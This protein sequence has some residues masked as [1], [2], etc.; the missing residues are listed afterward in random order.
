MW[1]RRKDIFT[2][3]D[4]IN[5]SITKV[6]VEQPLA[7][8]GSA[9][10]VDLHKKYAK[11]RYIMSL[12]IITQT[13]TLKKDKNQEKMGSNWRKNR[14]PIPAYA[15]PFPANSSPFQLIPA[16]FS[17]FKPISAYSN[18]FQH[19]TAYN[20]LSQYITASSS[21]FLLISSPFQ[22]IPAAH[23]RERE[24][25][26]L[27]LGHQQYKQQWAVPKKIVCTQQVA[28]QS[29]IWTGIHVGGNGKIQCYS[30]QQNDFFLYIIFISVREH[31]YEA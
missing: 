8:P 31:F 11:H 3:H 6:F 9:K 20:S 27:L 19:I 28:S 18:L 14:K 25:R 12:K 15:S 10:K 4:S 23:E 21:L 29:K 13:K 26:A 7:S 5:Q 24:R 30:L 2:N 16:Y 1:R 22:P 17:Q